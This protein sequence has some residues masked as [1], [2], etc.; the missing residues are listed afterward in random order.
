MMEQAFAVRSDAGR[1]NLGTS[2]QPRQ[3]PDMLKTT[4]LVATHLNAP[5][6]P[7]VAEE[8]IARSFR[9]GRVMTRSSKA[10]AIMAHLF[11]E[12]EPRLVV[13]CAREIGVPLSMV[14]ALY[15]DT[16]DLGAPVCPPWELAVE[17]LL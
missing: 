3:N 8:D 7:I 4:S 13:Q 5:Y 16:L 1:L 12:I 6:G 9:A 2:Q 14:D 15:R 11:I 10:S 17:H